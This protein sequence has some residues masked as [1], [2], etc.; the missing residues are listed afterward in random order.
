VSG[1]RRMHAIGRPRFR[2]CPVLGFVKDT[3][4]RHEHR[5]KFMSELFDHFSA[6]GEL[7]EPPVIDHSARQNEWFAE[8]QFKT[9]QMI[10]GLGED[11][12]I[13]QLISVERDT[14]LGHAAAR[15]VPGVVDANKDA[16]HVGL[17]IERI[18]LPALLEI[19]NAV[20]ADA[21]VVDRELAVG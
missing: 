12:A 7:G 15:A 10:L 9:R 11:L 3:L 1:Q 8:H 19:G 14:V 17:D 6:L 2:R 20:A 18:E 5:T 16:K 4:E 13:D 21:A